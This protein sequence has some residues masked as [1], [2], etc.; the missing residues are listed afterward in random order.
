LIPFQQN[1]LSFSFDHNPLL[2]PPIEIAV[3]G[4]SLIIRYF[5]E[6]K[7]QGTDYLYE[8]KMLIVGQ[9]RAG[10]TSL[11]FKLHNIDAELPEEEGTTRGI[12]IQ[13]MEF[14]IKDKEGK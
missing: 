14:D 4:R 9:P 12:D 11:R 5:E 10:K 8:A 2:S 6:L 13:P 7:Q 3:L 1:K